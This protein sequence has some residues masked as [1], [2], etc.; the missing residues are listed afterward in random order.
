MIACL[1]RE[2]FSS[3]YSLAESLDVSPAAVSR[4]LHNSLG[5][6]NFHLRWVSHQLTSKPQQMRVAKCGEFLRALEVMQRTHFRHIIKGD[7][8]W[9]YLEYQYASQ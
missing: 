1:E 9:F 3:A 4:R 6:K 8:S 2:P 7:A 5:M